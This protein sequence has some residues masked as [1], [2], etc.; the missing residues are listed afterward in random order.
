MG[1]NGRLWW[2]RDGGGALCLGDVSMNV[3]SFFVEA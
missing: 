2:G 1:G 3:S